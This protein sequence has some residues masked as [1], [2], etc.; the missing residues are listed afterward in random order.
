MLL[1]L[2]CATLLA[3]VAGSALAHSQKS[4]DR[5]IC[6]NN[7]RQLTQA[8]QMY[9]DDYS[10]VLMANSGSTASLYLNWVNGYMDFTPSNPDNVNTAYLTNAAYAAMGQYVKSPA[11]FRCPADLSTVIRSG[12]PFL[13]VRSYSMNG[14]VGLGASAWS[15]GYQVMTNLAQVPQPERIFVLLEEHPQSINDGIFVIDV[16]DTGPGARLIDC[17]AYYHLAGLNLAMADGHVEYWQWADPR[18]MPPL[19][20]PFLGNLATPNNPDVARLQRVTSYRP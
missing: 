10:G 2:A 14:Y 20:A 5:A 12:V 13:R 9:A 3:L 15:V 18:T 4:S 11:F 19:D 17:P 7:L 1:V 6:A 16:A 8:W